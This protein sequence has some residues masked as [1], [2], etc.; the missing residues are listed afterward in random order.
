M[1][2]H[3]FDYLS[4]AYGHF[5]GARLFTY[6]SFRAITSGI[7]A[8]CVSIWFGN[9]FINFMKRRNI[10]E[11]TPPSTPSTWP[12]KACPPWVDS[13]SLPRSSSRVCCSA[14]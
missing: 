3:L 7:I 6:I 13:S 11:T 1:L 9:A 8:L 12:R 14:N 5:A 2:Y 10:T 4:S